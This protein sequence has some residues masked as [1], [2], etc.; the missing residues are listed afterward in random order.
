[1]P[2]DLTGMHIREGFFFGGGRQYQ[3]SVSI[4]FYK[5]DLIHM[6]QMFVV[7]T[8]Q[9]SRSQIIPPPAIWW[10]LAPGFYSLM[11]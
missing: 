3:K 1:M 2:D 11:S 7:Q 9:E 4:F 6:P 10:M 5:N 8:E